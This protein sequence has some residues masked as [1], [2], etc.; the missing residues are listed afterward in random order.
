MLE[1]HRLQEALA[2]VMDPRCLPTWLETPNP[3][4]DELKPLEVIERGQVDR[5]WRMIF[6]LQSGTPG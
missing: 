5:I 3:A 4:F 1:T 6:E 2:M